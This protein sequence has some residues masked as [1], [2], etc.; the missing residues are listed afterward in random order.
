MCLK[1]AKRTF[2]RIVRLFEKN[3]CAVTAVLV[4]ALLGGVFFLGSENP[5]REVEPVV[6]GV[7]RHEIVWGNRSE[8]QVIFTFD[9]GA[10]A[11]SGEAILSALKK[12]N[13]KGTFFL[14][15]KFV[16]KNQELVK[17]ISAEGHEIFNHTYSHP[18]LTALSDEHIEDELL[19]TETIVKNLTGKSTKP[20]FRPPFG[21]RNERVYTVALRAG[22]Q[23][24]YWTTDALDWK[25]S[26]GITASDVKSRIFSN[27]APG[28]IYLMHLGDT[29][30]GAVLDEVLTEIEA[31]GYSIVS[32]TEGI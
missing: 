25:E 18:D 32:L 24:V 28:A 5:N 10:T 29:L 14:T 30:T 9:G 22:F 16:E 1:H 17:K 4:L 7:E 3:H 12:H 11:E 27:L 2:R 23:S 20:Y 8:K 26:Q 21:A 15:G 13:V 31:R 6:T 19:R